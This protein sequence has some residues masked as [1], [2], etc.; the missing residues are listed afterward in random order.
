MYA[1]SK[2]WA[3]ATGIG[4]IYR[5]MDHLTKSIDVC[6]EA[7]AVGS[8]SDVFLKDAQ[9]TASG[10]TGVGFALLKGLIPASGPPA[11]VWPPA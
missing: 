10:G 8:G 6:Q 7:L 4:A 11:W 2:A 9:S 3:N 1:T 5:Y